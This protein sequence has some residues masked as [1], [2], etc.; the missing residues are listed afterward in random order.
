MSELI[1]LLGHLGSFKQDQFAYY[2]SNRSAILQR[3]YYS[4][5]DHNVIKYL[6]T[7]L[8]EVGDSEQRLTMI[9]VLH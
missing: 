4:F 5:V 9:K 2:H 7:C 8:I 1:L 6:S 3:C